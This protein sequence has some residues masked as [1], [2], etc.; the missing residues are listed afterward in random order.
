MAEMSQCLY[1][2]PM[3]LEMRKGFLSEEGIP[4]VILAM[5]SAP[6][7]VMDMFGVAGSDQWTRRFKRPVAE[8]TRPTNKDWRHNE[9]EGTPIPEDSVQQAAVTLP[10]SL[11][12]APQTLEEVLHG[13]ASPPP[14][15]DGEGNG[16]V[17]RVL[18]GAASSPPPCDGEENGVAAQGGRAP[19]PEVSSQSPSRA[20]PPSAAPP[21][22]PA[23]PALAD[24]DIVAMALG[25]SPEH[26]SK[27][28][29]LWGPAAWANDEMRQARKVPTAPPPAGPGEA[30]WQQVGPP[31][32]QSPWSSWASSGLSNAKPPVL[33]L[34]GLAMGPWG[35]DREFASAS[36]P[37]LAVTTSPPKRQPPAIVTMESIAAQHKPGSPS[38]F[39]P[40]AR[41]PTAGS[42]P[43]RP[44]EQ[45]T[46][47]K[48]A[49]LIPAQLPPKSVELKKGVETPSE[50]TASVVDSEESDDDGQAADD[51]R[52]RRRRRKKSAA[53]KNGAPAAKAAGASGARPGPLLSDYI[54]GLSG[55]GPGTSAAPPSSTAP[56]QAPSPTGDSNPANARKVSAAVPAVSPSPE[57]APEA[58]AEEVMVECISCRK[59]VPWRGLDYD[60]KC[61]KCQKP[62]LPAWGPPR[63]PVGQS[64]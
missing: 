6:P 64:R 60:G 32:E 38:S 18:H 62:S 61:A 2:R 63:R 5:S 20:P 35:S 37:S 57:P 24:E 12:A 11:G 27:D 52:K 47:L 45:P 59:Q 40:A 31:P 50:L 19:A 34:A 39:T 53:A 15:C 14:P 1:E 28:S 17:A 43:A 49:D 42:P 25:G 9:G 7:R 8:R 56:R 55:A 10:P 26:L 4:D 46:V 21:E 29:P 51:K 41:V 33:G 3:M 13:S 16:A 54:P 36:Q 44:P 23:L 30:L 58:A 22:S 48:V